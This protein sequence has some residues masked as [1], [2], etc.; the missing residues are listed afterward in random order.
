MMEKDLDDEKLKE[1]VIKRRKR[2]HPQETTK[3][4]IL[5]PGTNVY[6]KSDK[7]KIKPRHE[8]TIVKTFQKHGE[9]YATIQKRESQ[10]RSKRYDVKMTEIFPLPGQR[11]KDEENE[12][13]E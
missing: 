5:Q 6:I 2:T 9:T 13:E 8:Y 1:E 7:S 12:E 11:K 4:T 10:F 3:E